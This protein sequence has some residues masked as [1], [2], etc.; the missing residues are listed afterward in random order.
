MAS[1]TTTRIAQ[2]MTQGPNGRSH[3]S[4]SLLLG[5]VGLLVCDAMTDKAMIDTILHAAAASAPETDDKY[6]WVI[7]THL[8]KA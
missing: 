5:I 1:P 4:H 6:I 3:A 7:S 2:T 8:C